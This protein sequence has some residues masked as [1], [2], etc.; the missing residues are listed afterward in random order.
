MNA[1]ELLKEKCYEALINISGAIQAKFIDQK[2][3][4]LYELGIDACLE[5]VEPLLDK[6]PEEIL[7]FLGHSNLEGYIFTVASNRIHDYLRR[8][9]NK[10]QKVHE[11]HSN[12][13]GLKSE[14][15]D[16]E[17]GSSDIWIKLEQKL[18]ER[19]FEVLLTR[20]LEEETYNYIAKAI[21]TTEGNARKIFSR[22]VRKARK[23]L[24]SDK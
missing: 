3:E 22:T 5:I 20:I 16:K 11:E 15:Q 6:T 18:T 9:G 14:N 2:E 24:N 10:R 7:D 13:F 1:E 8:E 19:E 17:I 12:R 21:G 23:I 4:L